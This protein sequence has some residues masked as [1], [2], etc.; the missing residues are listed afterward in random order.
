M[1]RSH[2]QD[3][4]WLGNTWAWPLYSGCPEVSKAFSLAVAAVPALA[5]AAAFASAFTAA[6]SAAAAAP[7]ASAFTVAA[8]AAAVAPVASASMII[9]LASTCKKTQSSS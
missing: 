4:E 8:S 1:P 5:A 7:V 9:L 6:V 3:T 2:A